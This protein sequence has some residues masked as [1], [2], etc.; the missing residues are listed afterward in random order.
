MGVQLSGKS[1]GAL[2]VLRPLEQDGTR[3]LTGVQRAVILDSGVSVSAQGPG[4]GPGS[5]V[6]RLIKIPS[7]GVESGA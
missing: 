5:G 7:E 3:G 6:Q 2:E 4:Q 1:S